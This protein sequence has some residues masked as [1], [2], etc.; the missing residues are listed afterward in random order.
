MTTHDDTQEQLNDLEEEEQR[1]IRELHDLEE[2]ARAD[3]QAKHR[4]DQAIH[5]DP[6]GALATLLQ[7]CEKE[8]R[9]AKGYIAD[10]GP[11]LTIV[12]VRPGDAAP[13]GATYLSRPKN[14]GVDF[15]IPLTTRDYTSVIKRPMFLNTIREKIKAR[16]YATSEDYLEDMRL[17]ARNTAAFN[18][19]VEL[20]WVVQHARLLLEAAED[21]VTIRRKK[22]YEIEDALRHATAS[23]H[24]SVAP[25]PSSA[26]KRKRSS[27]NPATVETA[28][29]DM[30]LPSVGQSIEV[31][32]PNYRR[33]FSASVVGK[34][35][36]N[37]HVIY[38]EDDTDQWIDLQ[39]KMKW[40]N[41]NVRAAAASTKTRRGQEPPAH[42]RR[43]ASA[44]APTPNADN[45]PPAV[46]VPPA[47]TA[48]DIE[49][50]RSDISEKLDEVSVNI[51]NQ[52]KG[53]L[54]RIDRLLLRSDQMERVLLAVQDSRE[55]CEDRIG[56]IEAWQSRIDEKLNKILSR[57]E[58]TSTKPLVDA[59][60]N[61]DTRHKNEDAPAEL[62]G[63]SQEEAVTEKLKAGKSAVR[64]EVIVVDNSSTDKQDSTVGGVGGGGSDGQK[65]PAEEVQ[66]E[67][68]E[69][70]PE[71]KPDAPEENEETD[72]MDDKPAEERKSA[73]ADNKDP[74][75]LAV[76]ESTALAKSQ[77]K[78]AGHVSGGES[79]VPMEV[80]SPVHSSGNKDQSEALESEKQDATQDVARNK[81]QG[82]TQG[83]T[84][85]AARDEADGA[86]RDEA[87]DV[88]RYGTQDATRHETPDGKRDE[89][90]GA[91][92]NGKQD[93]IREKKQGAVRD[94]TQDATRDEAK[95]ATQKE[96]GDES[97][98]SSVKET[99]IAKEHD[100]ADV[101][102]VAGKSVV[103]REN[104]ASRL[105]IGAADDEES[106]DES[107]GSDDSDSDS[108]SSGDDII[109][110]QNG[111]PKEGK[112]A[113]KPSS[114]PA[115]R[116]DKV[117]DEAKA[118]DAA[119]GDVIEKTEGKGVDKADGADAVG[120]SSSED[121][122]AD[123]EE[124]GKST[125]A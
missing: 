31:Y 63:G 104:D 53:H 82:A 54:E 30:K 66:R 23:K 119:Q 49:G 94:E 124:E 37:V 47:L 125:K 50:L 88:T 112:G 24:R 60:S 105:T 123:G 45:P 41:R 72:R 9:E 113:D 108:S 19:G 118:D 99:E 65:R 101:G 69:K 25:T 93:A 75:D 59:G 96:D 67:N 73:A 52:L 71:K 109:K 92:R 17:L 83:E 58:V 51:T 62:L 81:T 57:I 90:Q 12:R 115:A 10:H 84:Q 55:S 27:Q 2:R 1:I 35:G 14:T 95:D 43:K 39:G 56:R 16:G 89:A 13:K 7:E 8:V 68:V 102:S 70:V 5:D 91:A 85:D 74:P 64:N 20:S 117:V 87:Q 79:P 114:K 103:K 77:Q 116:D 4:H 32:W 122:S 78:A 38:D 48:Q 106:S 28:N 26:G 3:E 36:T 33:W 100:K 107:D 110:K 46:H 86:T 40:R 18:K 11:P 29:G 34:S 97:R 61:R 120:D 42:K 6:E 76:D 80:A 111:H 98:L 15:T 22:F 44:S 121:E 21:A